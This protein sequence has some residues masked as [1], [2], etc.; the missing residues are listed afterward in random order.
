MEKRVE[1]RRPIHELLRR[2]WSPRAFLERP[3]EPEKLLTLLEAARWAPSCYNEQP[4]SFI[5][6]LKQDES[7]Y[8]RLLSCLVEGNQLWAQ[9]APVLMLS[10]ARLSFEA[11]GE[12]NRHAFHDVGMAA[13]SLTL[14]AT[15]LGLSVHHMAGFHVEKA[16][17]L[18]GIP[19]SHEPV[20]V[21]AI[22]YSSDSDI[23]PEKLRK[24]ERAARVRKPLEELV[25]AGLWGKTAPLVAG[26]RMETRT[27]T[28]G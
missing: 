28:I 15:A 21:M 7:E 22:G 23:L 12:I 18:F 19:H 10:I 25:Y 13:Q 16:R 24:K 14:Q 27:I 4:W 1:T 11:N 26:K 20:A 17:E 9:R 5:L 3:V 8:N 2:R 6:A